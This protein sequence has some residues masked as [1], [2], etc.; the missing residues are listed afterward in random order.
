MGTVPNEIN[1]NVTQVLVEHAG[2]K[3]GRINRV[4]QMVKSVTRVRVRVRVRVMV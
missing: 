1:A 2:S 3:V 4:T